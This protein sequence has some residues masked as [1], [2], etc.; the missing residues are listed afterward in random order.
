M[1]G[2]QGRSGRVRKPAPSPGFDPQTVQP[3]ASRYTDWA[4]R[5]TMWGGLAIKPRYWCRTL[6][7]FLYAYGL[8]VLNADFVVNM[9]ELFRRVELALLNSI[10]NLHADLFYMYLK[11]HIC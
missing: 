3:V 5:P 10:L 7:D 1:C 4:N 11:F 6:L 9:L 8:T 2:L